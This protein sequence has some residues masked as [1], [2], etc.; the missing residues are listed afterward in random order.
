M[1]MYIETIRDTV[2]VHLSFILCIMILAPWSDKFSLGLY[3]T[4]VASWQSIHVCV[5]F[6]IGSVFILAYAKAT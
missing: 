2:N 6:V 1:C 3:E 5:C 4:Y